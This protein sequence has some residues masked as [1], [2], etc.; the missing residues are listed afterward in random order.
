MLKKEYNNLIKIKKLRL[1]NKIRFVKPISFSEKEGLITEFIEGKNLKDYLKEKIFFEFGK[2]LKRL[3]KKNI[4]HGQLEAQDVIYKNGLFYLVDI[5]CL[6]KK[7]ALEDYSRFKISIHLHQIKNFLKWNK[8]NKCSDAFTRGYGPDQSLEK[9]YL[10]KE[11]YQIVSYYK[12]R[13]FVDK[14]K[15]FFIDFVLRKRFV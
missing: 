11:L 9:E 3:H 5:P 13:R 8:Y 14:I 4:T 1:K 10:K 15:G 6:N 12:K 2:E 7:K